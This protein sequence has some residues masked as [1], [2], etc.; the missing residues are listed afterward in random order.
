MFLQFIAFRQM[1]QVK[2]HA[3]TLGVL[4]KGDIPFLVSA[5]SADVWQWRSGFRLVGPLR[6]PRPA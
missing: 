2:E 3:N 4:L 5:D 6:P 1:R